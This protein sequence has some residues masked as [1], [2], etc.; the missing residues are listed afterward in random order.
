[1]TQ[2]WSRPDL[3]WTE[4][5]R[6]SATLERSWWAWAGPHGGLV[7]S[8]AVAAAEHTCQGQQ[9]RELSAQFLAAPVEGPVELEVRPL[10]QGGSS[11]VLAVTVRS[12]EEVALAATVL[13]GRSRPGLAMQ[14]VP[15]PAVPGVER[16]PEVDLPVELV[17]YLQNLDYRPATDT[18]LLGGHPRA[19]FIGWLRLR[20][21]SAL[22]A[23]ALTVL[24]DA[25]PPG[26][27]ATLT[28]PVPV[29]TVALSVQY[30]E[31]ASAR[32]SGWVLVRIRTRSAGDGW[33]V[34]DS[35]LWDGDGR[36]LASARQTRRVLEPVAGR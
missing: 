6:A 3:T 10:R 35:D 7:A 5:A 12:G 23:Q 8:L 17:A 20:D 13:L 28:A 9:V 16:C 36:L 19:E 22:D 4:S 25:P 33:C 11:T 30:V 18:P 29:P 27:Y 14:A 32:D 24:L 15:A 21:H 31:P 34:D 1:M 26:L 2:T